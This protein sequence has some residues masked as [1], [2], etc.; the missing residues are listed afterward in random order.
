LDFSE[1]SQLMTFFYAFTFTGLV[2]GGVHLLAWNAP[3]ANEMQWLWLVSVVVVAASGPVLFGLGILGK[4]TGLVAFLL[5]PLALLVYFA[6]SLYLVVECFI[7]SAFL[8]DLVYE[9]VEW[10]QYF[11]HIS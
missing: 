7:Y 9:K 3:L 8:P 5:R 1:L 10:S 6:A 4:F 2:Y 11:P